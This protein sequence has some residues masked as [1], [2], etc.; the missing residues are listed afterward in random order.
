MNW[1]IFFI[2]F[3]LFLLIGCGKKEVPKDT[4]SPPIEIKYES[5]Q[6]CYVHKDYISCK[7]SSGNTY[8]VTTETQNKVIAE[9]TTWDKTMWKNES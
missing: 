9:K 7:L 1:K 8:Y 3:I 2:F 4:D 5:I 6:K